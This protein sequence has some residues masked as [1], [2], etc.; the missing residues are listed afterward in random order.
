[1]EVEAADPP[2]MGQLADIDQAF[3]GHQHKAKGMS[4]SMSLKPM[5]GRRMAGSPC[6]INVDLRHGT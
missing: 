3:D 4:S 5:P 1:M 2:D 6:D